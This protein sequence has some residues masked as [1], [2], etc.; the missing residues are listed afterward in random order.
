M[1]CNWCHTIVLANEPTV[2]VNQKVFHE[3]CIVDWRSYWKEVV[4][5]NLRLFIRRPD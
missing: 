4:K 5:A 1:T 3:T 2:A